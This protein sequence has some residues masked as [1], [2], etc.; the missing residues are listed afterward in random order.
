MYNKYR[1]QF[2]VI[3]MLEKEIGVPKPLIAELKHKLRY[4]IALE[5]MRRFQSGRCVKDFG[6][7]SAILLLPIIGTYFDTSL[8]EA[9]RIC[10]DEPNFNLTAGV[11][12]NFTIEL[13]VILPKKYPKIS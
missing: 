5:E 6:D 2:E 4:E 9:T 10:G 1:T 7:G 13:L 8:D 3:H 12:K 11:V